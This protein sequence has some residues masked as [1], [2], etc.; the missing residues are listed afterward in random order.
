MQAGPHLPL[1]NTLLQ[2]CCIMKG[3]PVFSHP[4]FATFSEGCFSVKATAAGFRSQTV[5]GVAADT[6]PKLVVSRH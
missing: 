5:L 2:S 3:R 4:L 1:R 6:R